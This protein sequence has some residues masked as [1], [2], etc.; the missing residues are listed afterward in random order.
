MKKIYITIAIVVTLIFI[1][2]VKKSLITKSYDTEIMLGDSVTYEGDYVYVKTCSCPDETTYEAICDDNGEN[3]S[4]SKTC[5][6]YDDNGNVTSQNMKCTT[7]RYSNFIDDIDF[8][9]EKRVKVGESFTLTGTITPSDT[10]LK[11]LTWRTSL[12][13]NYNDYEKINEYGL[14]GDETYP[15]LYQE[16]QGLSHEYALSQKFIAKNPGVVYVSVT[17]GNSKKWVTKQLMN[18][19]LLTTECFKPSYT[20]E[21]S[22]LNS[23]NACYMS[24]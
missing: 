18:L 24:E 9:Q 3:C 20:K 19:H 21:K 22:V 14:H 6:G 5:V 10:Y 11:K 13:E 15:F 12:Y 16:F 17:G 23:W 4:S 7:R 2:L 8:C 1:I